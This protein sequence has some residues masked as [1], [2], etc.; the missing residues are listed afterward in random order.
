MLL[1]CAGSFYENNLKIPDQF[2]LVDVVRIKPKT[3]TWRGL[4]AET[5][6]P[7]IL[8]DLKQKLEEK[9]LIGDNT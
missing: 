1:N 2:V 3:A 8:V 7:L 4:Q 6:N 9:K 5:K